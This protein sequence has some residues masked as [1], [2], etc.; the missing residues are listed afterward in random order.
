LVKQHLNRI[1]KNINLQKEGWGGKIGKGREVEGKRNRSGKVG[2]G[3][4]GGE[5]ARVS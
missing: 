1:I 3:G 4:V 5:A 2:C